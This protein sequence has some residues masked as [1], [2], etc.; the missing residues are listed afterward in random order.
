MA[1]LTRT[2]AGS[3]QDRAEQK[4]KQLRDPTPTRRSSE[5]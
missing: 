5:E 4:I 3:D 2:A 1:T